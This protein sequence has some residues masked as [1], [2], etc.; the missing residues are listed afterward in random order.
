VKEKNGR[1]SKRSAGK[2]Y[3]AC[4]KKQG[5]ICS[6]RRTK[7]NTAMKS[8]LLDTKKNSREEKVRNT[9]REWE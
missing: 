4:N 8:K 5:E 2:K 9:D 3:T 6:E 7:R 1:R